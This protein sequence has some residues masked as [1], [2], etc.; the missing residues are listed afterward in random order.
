MTG[1]AAGT[2]TTM[3]FQAGADLRMLE[4]PCESF[5]CR[6]GTGG[7]TDLAKRTNSCFYVIM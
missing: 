6:A 4:R 3:R 5:R 2:L 7:G 1:E